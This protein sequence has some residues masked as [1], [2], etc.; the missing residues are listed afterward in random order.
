MHLQDLIKNRDVEAI[1]A[2]M[3]EK[4]LVVRGNKI[5]PCDDDAKKSLE[6]QSG[7]WN[8]RQQAR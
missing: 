3:K 4:R 5:V 2:Y 7:F 8:Q 6:A 1:K